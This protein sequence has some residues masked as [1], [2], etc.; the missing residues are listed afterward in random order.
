MY[1]IKKKLSIIY[2]NESQKIPFFYIT[3]IDKDPYLTFVIRAKHM[4][5][6]CKL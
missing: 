4:L 2:I 3:Y 5:A 1:F 6:T